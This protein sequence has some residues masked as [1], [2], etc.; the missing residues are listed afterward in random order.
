MTVVLAVQGISPDS[1]GGKEN[2]KPLEQSA[3][4]FILRL[5]GAKTKGVENQMTAYLLTP[6]QGLCSSLRIKTRG[7]RSISDR[8]AAGGRELIQR[9]QRRLKL[10][11]EALP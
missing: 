8:E 7:R 5:S 4:A 10:A 1:S 3:L 6:A 2:G 11:V 9:S